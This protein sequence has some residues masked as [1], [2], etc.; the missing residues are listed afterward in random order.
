LAKDAAAH[1]AA[2]RDHD[3]GGD[4]PAKSSHHRGYRQGAGIP[5]PVED[6]VGHLG[7]SLA[8][9]IDH[10]LGELLRDHVAQV[11]DLPVNDPQ[12]SQRP[13]GRERLG[14]RRSQRPRRR[15]DV[16]GLLAAQA[17]QRLH[18]RRDRGA[19]G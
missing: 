10:R 4:E 6:S 18:V 1:L 2:R 12:L 16:V 15:Q 9:V 3:E 5:A 11:Q 7:D 14:R 17:G 8:D 13:L 19:G